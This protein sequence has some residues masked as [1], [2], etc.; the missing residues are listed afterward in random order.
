MTSGYLCLSQANAAGYCCRRGQGILPELRAH[1]PPPRQACQLPLTL[2]CHRQVMNGVIDGFPEMGTK[3][4]LRDV[5][6]K[7]QLK[8]LWT[9]TRGGGWCRPPPF[10]I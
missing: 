4:G 9:W 8:G 7:P 1:S 6:D 3:V 10:G 5:V 2:R